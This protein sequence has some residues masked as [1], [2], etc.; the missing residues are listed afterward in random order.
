MARAV[1][2]RE[3]FDD[4]VADKQYQGVSPATISF[5]SRNWRH[6]VRDTGVVDV[7]DLNPGVI[8]RWLLIHQGVSPTTLATYDRSLRVTLNWFEKHG[9]VADGPMKALPKRRTPRTTVDT[10]T[11]AE[12][13]AIIKKAK[14]GRYPRRDVALAS[15]LL[16]TGLRIGEAIGLKLEDVDWVESS[17]QVTGKAGP[18]VVPFGRG[19]IDRVKIRLTFH[20]RRSREDARPRAGHALI[21]WSLVRV[22]QGTA[23]LERQTSAMAAMETLSPGIRAGSF[24]PCRAGG[25]TGNHVTYASFMPA[26]SSSSASTMVTLTI[27][28]IELPASSKMAAMLR[29]HWCVCSCTVVPTILPVPP[30]VGAVPETNTSPPAFTAWLYVAGGLPALSVNTML[31]GMGAPLLRQTV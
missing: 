12:A 14:K 5:Y 9:Y 10:F 15:P 18:R 3:A 31:R 11:L 23:E 24:A 6:F 21:A 27:L 2:L 30:S 8:R 26:K 16:D 7:A 13:Q 19:A 25:S 4:F 1:S 17:V 20:R 28:S 29:R 22:Q